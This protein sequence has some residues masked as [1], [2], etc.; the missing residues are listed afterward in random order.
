MTNWEVTMVNTQAPFDVK[1]IHVNTQTI[2]EAH[3]EAEKLYPDYFIRSARFHATDLSKE[4]GY[5]YG[6]VEAQAV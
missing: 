6:P 3:S 5:G 1:R 4:F 2:V